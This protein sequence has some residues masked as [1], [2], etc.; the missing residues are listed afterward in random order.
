M[1]PFIS[2]SGQ[3]GRGQGSYEDIRRTSGESIGNTLS[4]FILGKTCKK[5]N[6]SIQRHQVLCMMHIFV[7]LGGALKARMLV[8]H[9]GCLQF[10]QTEAAGVF[11]ILILGKRLQMGNIYV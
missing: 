10:L 3:L 8:F 9:W 11:L 1:V 6:K 7:E 5:V 2:L 4:F